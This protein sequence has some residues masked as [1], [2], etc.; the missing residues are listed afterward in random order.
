MAVT[1]ELDY[2]DTCMTELL[3]RISSHLELRLGYE[4]FNTK[5]A[6]NACS[7]AEDAMIATATKLVP[8]EFTLYWD[9]RDMKDKQ[10]DQ[11]LSHKITDAK[12]VILSLY[13]ALSALGHAPFLDRISLDAVDMIPEY[14][15][16]AV[17][18]VIAVTSNLWQSYWCAVEL[19]TAVVLH[20]N[21]IL[22]ILLVSVEGDQWTE[23][24]G[25]NTGNTLSFPTPSVM[26]QNFGKW[27][28]GGNTYCNQEV[29]RLIGKLYG[30]GEY[31]ET[32]LVP[33]TL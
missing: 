3:K 13:N 23:V 22:N 26:M 11:Y 14:V 21:G 33:H 28:P 32:R 18:F 8:S 30:G 12:D 7:A 29:I 15:E 20:R 2:K 5:A 24:A 6:V 17:T 19:C 1:W 25:E 27:F 9:V 4:P 31:T 10:Y 16:Q